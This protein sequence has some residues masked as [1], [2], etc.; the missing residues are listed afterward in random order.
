METMQIPLFQRLLLFAYWQFCHVKWLNFF[1]Q[2][3]PKTDINHK[4]VNEI[5]HSQKITNLICWRFD[6]G[7]WFQS[8]MYYFIYYANGENIY[9]SRNVENFLS[10]HY[11]T[12]YQGEHLEVL[13]YIYTKQTINIL[14]IK[15][16]EILKL[17]FFI[18]S[19]WF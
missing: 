13:L 2:L 5:K 18:E 19:Y 14:I 8:W 11:V 9:Q 12:L 3:S 10:F 17:V 16:E 4:N 15:T 6:M 7:R 1:V